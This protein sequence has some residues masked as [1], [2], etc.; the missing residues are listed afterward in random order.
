MR[1]YLL[2]QLRPG[3]VRHFIVRDHQIRD[4]PGQIM[5][6]VLAV[7]A[8]VHGEPLGA[9]HEAD[10]ASHAGGVI[11]DQHMRRVIVRGS[12][13]PGLAA[14]L[15]GL[16]QRHDPPVAQAIAQHEILGW[17]ADAQHLVQAGDALER[18]VQRI[19]EQREHSL[20]ARQLQ[21]FPIPGATPDEFPHLLGDIKHLVHADAPLVADA[22]ATTAPLRAIQIDILGHAQPLGHLRRRRRGLLAGRAQPPGQTLGHHQVQRRGQ[23]RGLD[24]HVQQAGDGGGCI[25]RVQ[26]GKHQVT[27]LRRVHRDLGRLLVANLAHHHHV[28]ILAQDRA[29]RGRERHARRRVHLHL[30]EPP[31]LELHR[32]LDRDD[33]RLVVVDGVQEGIQRRRLAA[34]GGAGHQHRA[35]GALDAFAHARI[36]L[37]LE[38]QRIQRQ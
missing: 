8:L 1:P 9:Q 6:G 13:P 32:I 38:A 2:H 3:H 18:L 29:Q 35:A 28:R 5:P 10:Q 36:R 7:L 4:S 25:V 37:L 17:R 12:A 16:A 11:H 20:L 27:G 30:V 31:D 24:A 21:E 34:A 19:L 22:V 26:R 15:V 14:H 23:R 33:V